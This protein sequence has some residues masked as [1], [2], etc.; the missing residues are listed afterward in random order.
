[1]FLSL[2]PP[3]RTSRTLKLTDYRMEDKVKQS[4]LSFG[5]H[6]HFQLKS[7][8]N[9]PPNPENGLF[10][11]SVMKAGPVGFSGVCSGGGLEGGGRTALAH[12]YSGFA[13]YA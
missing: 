6:A 11:A 5:V 4:L 8:N 2:P 1:M 12:E 9:F 13:E 3:S 10:Y 7:L